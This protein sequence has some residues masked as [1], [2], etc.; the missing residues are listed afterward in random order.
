MSAVAVQHI[1][2]ICCK[3]TTCCQKKVEIVAQQ[4]Q[5]QKNTYHGVVVKCLH[6]YSFYIPP[7]QQPHTLDPYP[8]SH[9]YLPSLLP[10]KNNE[11]NTKQNP[12]PHPYS[13]TSPQNP[14]PRTSLKPNTP[15][16]SILLRGLK[17]QSIS[18]TPYLSP[19]T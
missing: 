3:K 10:I 13:S 1:Y 16:F 2:T 14:Q 6:H 15:S 11:N 8:L 17:L 18:T 4:Q 5:Q 9:P 12:L 7:S 19:Y